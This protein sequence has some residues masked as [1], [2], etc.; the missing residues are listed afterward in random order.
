MDKKAVAQMLEEIGTLLELKG[1]NPF[2]INAYHNAARAIDGVTEDLEKLIETKRLSEIPGIG[3]GCAEKITEFFTTGSLK[4]LEDLRKD[5]PPEL[6]QL[7]QIPGLGP[8]KAKI[9]YEKLKI[10]SVGELEY[11]CKENRLLDLKGFGA[12]TQEN[13]LKGIEYTRKHHGTFRYDQ[14]HEPAQ[15]ILKSIEKM[16]GV[17]RASIAGS[18]RRCKEIIHDIDILV[19]TKAADI[20]RIME[21]FTH[22]PGVEQILAEGETKSSVRMDSGIQVDLRIVSE[23]EYPF[24]LLYFTGSKEHNTLLRGLAKDK[25]LK[26]NEYGLFKGEKRIP[27]KTE[28]EIFKALGLS[29]IPPE[30]REAT[31]EIAWA[32]KHKSLDLIDEKD[33]Q[34]IFHVHST[35]SD[36]TADIETMAREAQKLGFKYMGLSDHSQTAAYAGG[37]SAK[38][39]KK[40]QAEIDKINK[41]L[42]GF[43]ILKGTESDILADGSLDYPE[44]VLKKFDF[45]IA[46]VHSRFK[47]GE[48]Q[49]TKRLIKALENP[50]TTMLGH[51]TG[52]L[53]LAREGYALNVDRIIEVAAKHK[54]I[55]EINASPHRFDIDW[56]YLKRAAEKGVR[57]SINPDAHSPEGLRDTFYGVGIARKGWLA[58][59]DVVNTMSLAEVEKYL[60]K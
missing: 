55:I 26:L 7:L 45:V 57:F 25:G 43:K 47:M 53:L 59:K 51:M 17:I 48:D 29:Y 8:K 28:E 22:L 21:K 30:L 5:F 49:M 9:L 56:R 23:Q 20:K 54:K 3:Q 37:L 50:Y 36:G 27:C 6:P 4:Y 12:K 46:S 58:K 1:E 35:W 11:A 13:I 10:S 60:S 18:L 38:D 15:Q 31:D 44:E 2:R 14:A 32:Q 52:R 33:I 19:S 39:L 42:K 40:Q 34:G 24:A 41:K 16:P